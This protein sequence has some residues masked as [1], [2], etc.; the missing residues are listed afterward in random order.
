MTDA[1]ALDPTESEP[2]PFP[3]HVGG[4]ST[5]SAEVDV[6]AIQE[7]LGDIAKVPL[8]RADT[9]QASLYYDASSMAPL[10]PL[11]AV[12]HPPRPDPKL[13]P[14]VLEAYPWRGL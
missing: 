8:D 7:I 5:D 14:P 10:S 4:V 6:R 3:E 11:A 9:S 2:T 12:R 13:P 1:P